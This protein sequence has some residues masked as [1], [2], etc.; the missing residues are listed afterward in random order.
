MYSFISFIA[1]PRIITEVSPKEVFSFVGYNK[2]AT[3]ECVF[4]G[5]PAPLVKM[6]NGSGTEVARGNSSASFTILTDSKDDFGR[7]NCSAENAHGKAEFSVELKIAGMFSVF[8][9]NFLEVV[10]ET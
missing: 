8:R 7:Y 3:V 9:L 2:P 1:P 5:Y 4:S 6:V 10:D